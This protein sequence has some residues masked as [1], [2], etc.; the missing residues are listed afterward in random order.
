MVLARVIR[1]LAGAVAAVIVIAIILHLVSANP[2]NVIVSDIHD[3]GQWL[4]GPFKNVFSVKNGNWQ[5]ILNWGLA[6]LVYA[7]VGGLIASLL[8]RS[9]PSWR[10]RRVG[11][12]A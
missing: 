10:S 9:T 1:A 6:A 4:V 7:L 2:H 3:A 8:A 5:I 12:A 11:P